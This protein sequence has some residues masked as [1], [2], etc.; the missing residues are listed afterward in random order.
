MNS[1]VASAKIKYK[2]SK[3]V[4]VWKFLLLFYTTFGIYFTIWCYE[5]WSFLKREKNLK[6][7]PLWRS[8]FYVFFAGFLAKH[9]K[10]FLEEKSI[11][12]DYSPT[13]IAFSCWFFIFAPVPLLLVFPDYKSIQLLTLGFAIPMVMLL[14]QINKYWEKEHAGLPLKKFSWWQITLLIFLALLY[15]C[16]ILICMIL[17]SIFLNSLTNI[18]DV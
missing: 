15:L 9:W 6:I 14:K 3:V 1:D 5:Q 17:I 4:P 2:Y 18:G 7:S 11:T 10:V 16:M 12:F 13:A 8:L